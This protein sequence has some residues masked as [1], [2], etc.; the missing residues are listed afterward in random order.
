ML[1]SHKE[2]QNHHIDQPVSNKYF[3]FQLRGVV[4]TWQKLRK[5]GMD[6]CFLNAFTVF[7]I[8]WLKSL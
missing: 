5:A 2:H 4:G 6:L 3:F 1:K 7:Y 8:L